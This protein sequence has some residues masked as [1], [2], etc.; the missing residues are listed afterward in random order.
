[1]NKDEELQ[2]LMIKY[3]DRFG[4]RYVLEIVDLN[5]EDFH[6]DFIKHALITGEPQDLSVF[7]RDYDY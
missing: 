3:Y 2:E 5:S 6:I 7:N 4:V 1:M